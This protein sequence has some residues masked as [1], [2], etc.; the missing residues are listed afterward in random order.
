VTQVLAIHEDT[1]ANAAVVRNGEIVAA[2]AEERLTRR[3]FQPGFPARAV[4]S[5]LHGA[6][7]SLDTMD[8]VVAGNR[9]HFLP[10]LLGEA[11]LLGE[12]DLFG[13]RHRSWTAL[14]SRIR[15]GGALARQVER[16]GEDA[17]RRRFDRPVPLVDHHTAH[18]YSAWVTSGF[19]EALAVS[20][21][22]LGDGW[23]ARV[24]RCGSG[25]CTP[26]WGS[27]A[28]HSPGQFYGEVTQL[29]GFHLMHAGKVTGLAA[30]GDPGPAYPLMEELFGL[31]RDDTEFRLAPAR[32]RSRRRGPYR[33]LRRFTRE[34][35]AAAAQQRL[36]D[37]VVAH[38]Q[39]AQ[40][41]TGLRRLVLAGGVFANVLLN[42]RL[43]NLPTV[44]GLFVHPAMTD[45]GIA[46]GAALAH[47]AEQGEASPRAMPHAYLGPEYDEETVGAALETSGL[48][49]RRCSDIERRVADLVVERRVVARF[50]GRLEYGPRALGH[51]SI[52]V[53]TADPTV[54]DWL[55]HRLGRSE[56]MPF[57]PATLA[58]HAE[59]CYEDYGPGIAHAA[60]FMTVTF[61]CSD[62][63]KEASPAVVHVDGTARPQVVHE[64][65]SPGLHRIL[66]LVHERTGV[67]SVVNTSLN[68]HGEPIVCSPQDAIRMVRARRVDALAI[69]PFLVNP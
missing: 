50:T 27:S 10:R 19:D 69:G 9:Y 4:D 43:W 39:R 53:H 64:D 20:I 48:R 52:L 1:N 37:V 26:L 23:S 36:E 51:R 61:R 42:Q 25:R 11:P 14:Q 22:N 33:R 17:L 62:A 8:A 59:R 5:V 18:A 35:V 63:M 44:D 6:D 16:F 13:L 2:V 66:S 15:R 58:A 24:F 56:F 57:A 45:Q 7:A 49:F 60:R 68:V 65:A 31:Q 38:V 55:N 32:A 67:P 12:H 40:D 34:Q 21:D 47:L 54:N 41:E 3:K 28:E 46:A 29:L 30:R